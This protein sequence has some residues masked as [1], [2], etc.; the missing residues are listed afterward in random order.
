MDELVDDGSPFTH[1]SDAGQIG[2]ILQARANLDGGTVGCRIGSI[3]TVHRKNAIHLPPPNQSKRR[4]LDD[5][6][7][8]N[9]MTVHTLQDSQLK[10]HSFAG[11]ALTDIPFGPKEGSF[12]DRFPDACGRVAVQVSGVATVSLGESGKL[13]DK[14][15]IYVGCYVSLDFDDLI[16]FSDEE[17]SIGLKVTDNNDRKDHFVGMVC[18]I[19]RSPTRGK[20][21]NVLLLPHFYSKQLTEAPSASLSDLTEDNVNKWWSGFSSHANAE[22]PTP[23]YTQIK[24]AIQNADVGETQEQDLLNLVKEFENMDDGDDTKCPDVTQ[25]SLFGQMI[26]LFGTKEFPGIADALHEGTPPKQIASDIKSRIDPGYYDSPV[27]S[28]LTHSEPEAKWVLAWAKWAESDAIKD[29]TRCS[30]TE[31]AEACQ[32]KL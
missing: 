19:S 28:V 11:I 4:R 21:L 30:K 22:A 1:N 32:T 2:A 8:Q 14:D 17:K 5:K 10:D 31:Q 24:T 9:L 18:D 6:D 25:T 3:C 15:E 26:M 16:E 29:I 27:G 13:L 7:A 23:K 12:A 20:Y